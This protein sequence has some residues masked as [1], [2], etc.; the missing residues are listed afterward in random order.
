MP[1]PMPKRSSERTRR[2][3]PSEERM[4][5]KRGMAHS[6]K[7]WP[8]PNKEWS[9]QVKQLWTSLGESGMEGFLEVSDIAYFRV[10]CDGL[11]E[12]YDSPAGRRSA[13]KLDIP[14]KH[15]ASLGITEGERRKM[16]IEL[17]TPEI[18]E[19]SVGSKARK[20]LE[21]KMNQ[22]ATVTRIHPEKEEE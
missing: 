20:M 13:M 15:M 7:K 14:L 5:I 11:Q 8:P 18:P 19:E 10:V 12:W 16:R 3:S 21:Q 2:E 22:P 17:E 4:P 9:S 1:G 6:Y